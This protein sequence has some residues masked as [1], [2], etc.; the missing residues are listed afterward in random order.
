MRSN[1]SCVVA[2]AHI[3]SYFQSFITFWDRLNPCGD[4]LTSAYATHASN[5][6]LFSG[7]NNELSNKLLYVFS[8]ERQ[9][10]YRSDAGLCDVLFYADKDILI[11]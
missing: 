5:G 3:R 11:I 10:R 1:A 4:G 7:V 6:T 8:G 2:R 9:Y